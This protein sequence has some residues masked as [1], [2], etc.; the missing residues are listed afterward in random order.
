MKPIDEEINKQ[1]VIDQLNWNASLDASEI[2]IDV[3]DTTVRLKGTVPNYIDKITAENTVY[4][5]KGVKNVENEIRIAHPDGIEMP[6]N[7]QITSNINRM[8]LWNNNITSANIKVESTKGITTLSGKVDSI[9]EKQLADD[10]AKSAKGVA[11]VVNLLEVDQ[12]KSIVDVDIE[13]DIRAAFRRNFFID[14]EQIEVSVSNGAVTLTGF[15]MNYAVKKEVLDIIR[16]TAGIIHIE[17]KLII[18]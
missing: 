16:H 9:W 3:I 15:V 13:S 18:Q 7:G 4:Q 8:L 14:P 11:G 5:V 10:I 12:S 2:R 17:D 6:Q 1:D